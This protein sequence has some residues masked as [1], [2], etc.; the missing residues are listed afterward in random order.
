MNISLKSIISLMLASIILLAGCSGTSKENGAD[1]YKF[2]GFSDFDTALY[3]EIIKAEADW[4]ESIQTPKGAI[5]KILGEPIAHINPYFACFAALGL[6]EAG[7]YESVKKYMDWHLSHINRTG[8]VNKHIGTIYDWMEDVMS[9]E[10]ASTKAYD[11]TD[12]YA[13]LFLMLA[14]S[15]IAK[16]GDKEYFKD[17]K[18]DIEMIYSAMMSTESSGLTWATPT[19]KVKYTMDNS[20]VYAG[21]KSAENLMRTFYNDSQKASEYGAKAKELSEAIESVL[22]NAKQ[23]RYYQGK[24]F[25]SVLSTDISNFYPD[26]LCQ[27]YPAL[28]GVI[29]SKGSR[30]KMIF[31]KFSGNHKWIEIKTAEYPM[32]LMCQAAATIGD[33]KN[34]H[35]FLTGVKAQYVD[36]G[37]PT[38]WY[39]MEAGCAIL[40]SYLM[41]EAAAERNV[42]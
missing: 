39:C 13:A 4:L 3:D 19:Y 20:E 9:G 14:D 6:V 7:R 27:F 26:A 12:S 21:I 24:G 31:S 10:E 33:Y 22:W 32:V 25:N 41:K 16:S 5:P 34:A 42:S 30:A 17:K 2:E 23:N 11:S 35:A 8:D 1:E 40:S 29:E 37:H 38:P 18:A 15:Y 28:F 36:K